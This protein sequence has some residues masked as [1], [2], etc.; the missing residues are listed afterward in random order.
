[1]TP[2]PLLEPKRTGGHNLGIIRSARRICPPTF[3][4]VAPPLPPH[5][6]F[7]PLCA[8]IILAGIQACR[9]MMV[10]MWAG[11]PAFREYMRLRQAG[12]FQTCRVQ[13]INAR[14]ESACMRIGPRYCLILYYPGRHGVFAG[15]TVWS[16]P[17]R[18]EIYIVYKRR[19][20]N[21]LR[22]LS[23]PVRHC[24]VLRFQLGAP[25][26][27]TTAVQCSYIPTV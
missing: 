16:M 18:F 20:I 10:C 15:K 21:T 12:C 11:I 27:R 6:Y 26:V 17:E 1:M 22:F 19:Y 3:K 5:I 9:V 24:P 25:V 4:I 7:N 23:F 2:P 8:T 14:K 13:R